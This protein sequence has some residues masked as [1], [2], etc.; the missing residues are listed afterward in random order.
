M[1]SLRVDYVSP[2]AKN[3]SPATDFFSS[4]QLEADATL[5]LPRASRSRRRRPSVTRGIPGTWSRRTVA[6][7]AGAEEA[8]EAAAA[9]TTRAPRTPTTGLPV[10][11]GPATEQRGVP[12]I[13]GVGGSPTQIAR[14]PWAASGGRPKTAAAA[15]S[16]RRGQPAVGVAQFT[17]SWAAAAVAADPGLGSEKERGRR[18]P[19]AATSWAG[20][21]L[22]WRR[23]Q[24]AQ[25]A[26]C[27][28]GITRAVTARALSISL[29][30][31]EGSAF[32][33]VDIADRTRV[34]AF[35]GLECDA[36]V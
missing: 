3:I 27:R 19:T 20:R 13:P 1:T 10:P 5:E 7:A 24:W 4:E 23:I 16:A 12:E 36:E 9:D 30:G 32:L 8:A 11:G 31:A 18:T 35:F 22:S 17:A 15:A 21:V 2:S 14:P 25:P 26:Y 28:G 34:V 6:A 33:V 29:C